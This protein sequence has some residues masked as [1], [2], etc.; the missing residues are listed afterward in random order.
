[1]AY[2]SYHVYPTPTEAPTFGA[3]SVV[4]NPANAT[5]SP[6]GW[7]D[8]NGAAGAESTVTTGNNVSAYTDTNNDNLP[9]AGSQPDGGAG[10]RSTSRSTS[11][12]RRRR[13]GRPR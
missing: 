7:H 2:D 1:M 11:P 12:R 10:C 8:T 4:T 13:T 5:A 9:D 3:R 6:F